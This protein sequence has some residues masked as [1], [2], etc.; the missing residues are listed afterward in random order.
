MTFTVDWTTSRL[1]NWERYLVPLAGKPL[2]AI[3]IGVFEGRS[4]L[5]LLENVLV[6]PECLLILVDSYRYQKPRKPGNEISQSQLNA[7]K[8]KAAS[9]LG[10]YWSRCWWRQKFS[11]EVLPSLQPG[12]F[13]MIRVDGDHRPHSTLQDMVLSWRLLKTGGLLIVDDVPSK[14][15]RGHWKRSGP[16]RAFRAFRS[17]VSHEIVWFQY[18]GCIRKL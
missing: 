2:K 1:P 14:Q 7:A 10:P 16:R 18:D 15:H 11:E 6:N 4:A 9:V 3:E 13:D 12:S 17:C 5:W 8:E